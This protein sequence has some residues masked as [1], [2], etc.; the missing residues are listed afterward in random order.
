MKKTLFVL[1]LC[2]LFMAAAALAEGQPV[3]PFLPVQAADMTLSY[4]EAGEDGTVT[5]HTGSVLTVP[6][7]DFTTGAAIFRLQAAAPAE[8]RLG[9]CVYLDDPEGKALVSVF[10]SP[11]T[12]ECRVPV[13]VEGVHDVFIAFEGEGTFTG[14]QVF[15]SMEDIEAAIRAERT[16]EYDDTIPTRYTVKCERAGTIES[17]TY[18]AHDYSND[19]ELYEKKAFV[20]LPYGYDP[21]QTYPLLILCHGI[22][23]NE[24]E[25]GMNTDTSKVKCIMDNLIDYGEIRPFIVV[26]PNGRA[27]RT[28]DS[29]SF[30]LFGKE[31]RYDLL[32]ALA[33]SYAVD[34]TDRSMCAMAGLSMGGMQTINMGIGECLDLFSAFGAFSAAPTS[35]TA[36]ITA[37]TIN[38]SEEY[39]IRIFYSICGTEDNIA[40]GAVRAAVDGLGALTDKLNDDNFIVQY[41]PGGHDFAVWYLGFYNFARLFGGE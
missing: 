32:P 34:I 5:V 18:E 16:E 33:E 37:A 25:W 7:V 21:E 6:Q 19:E 9:V 30:Y 14:W 20:Y 8:G 27:G 40:L 26:T 12:K 35:N 2:L 13:T 1:L 28:T 23:G 41:V 10:F 22:G 3:N 38:A 4:A 39:P 24:N 17:F 11:I 29:S 36:A 31:L 15:T